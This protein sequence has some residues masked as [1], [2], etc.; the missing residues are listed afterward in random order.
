MD[1]FRVFKKKH[2]IVL[3]CTECDDCF[4]ITPKQLCLLEKIN[5]KNPICPV[6]HPCSI[7]T[8]ALIPLKYTDKKG[9]LY[10]YQQVKQKI[11][12]QNHHSFDFGTE[13]LFFD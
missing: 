8:G 9:N 13:I 4:E 2:P 6:I 11:I 5:A 10:L 3:R 1:I 12:N 7:C